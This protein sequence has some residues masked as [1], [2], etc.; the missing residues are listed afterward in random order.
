M[1]SE[2]GLQRDVEDLLADLRMEDLE[3]Y[4]VEGIV[5]TVADAI[6]SDD[7]ITILVSGINARIYEHIALAVDLITI[8]QVVAEDAEAQI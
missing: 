7:L 6:A 4:Q 2:N 5:K 1:W 8:N 3:G